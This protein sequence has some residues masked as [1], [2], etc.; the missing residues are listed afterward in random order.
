M[1]R[2]MR[3]TAAAKCGNCHSPI[4]VKLERDRA[5]VGGAKDCRVGAESRTQRCEV[6]SAV[7]ADDQPV[8]T[9]PPS[10]VGRIG[11]ET[12]VMRRHQHVTTLRWR[13]QQA[14]Q[15]FA[16]Q[17]ARQQDSPVSVFEQQHDAVRVV[18]REMFVRIGMQHATFYAVAETQ[19]ISLPGELNG[20]ITAA[21]RFKHVS[22]GELSPI[23]KLRRDDDLSDRYCSQQTARTVDVI[24]IRV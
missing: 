21:C 5:V 1:L 24:G 12:A 22:D 6:G 23:K 2:V 17:I 11:S 7:G 20:D 4:G 10:E 16:F 18:G 14:E 15:A 19:R 3:D 8:G 13:I 9:G